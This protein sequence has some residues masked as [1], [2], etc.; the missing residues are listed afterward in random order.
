MIKY[1]ILG[2]VQGLTEFLPVSSSGHLVVLQKIFGIHGE[3]VA[4]SVILHLGTLLSVVIFF[5]KDILNM[6]RS[7]KMIGYVLAVTII[8]GVI[9]VAGKK[10]FE[11][12]FASPKAVAYAWIV[13][14]VVLF[15]TKRFMDAKREDLKLKDALILG[16]AQGFA[17]VPGISR[18][19]IT[20]ST[21]LFR[22]IN[23]ETAFKFSFIACLPA[24]L[25]AAVLEGKE[26]GFAFSGEPKSIIAGFILSLLS[27]LFALWFLRWVIKKAKFYYFGFYCLA[28]AILT[29]LFVK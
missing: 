7:I 25:G 2:I 15:L 24:I 11:E 29:L 3:E 18:A 14:A 9:G 8:T 10:I 22:K 1:A 5:F 4:I 27:G 26:I 13:T 28:I 17:I 16:L 21:L 20:I 6:L 12:L 19:G 23:K